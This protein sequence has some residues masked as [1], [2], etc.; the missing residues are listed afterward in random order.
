[1]RLLV[2]GG[3]QF[4]GRLTV[5][6]LLQE[7]HEVVLLNRGRTANPFE[8]RQRLKSIKCDRMGGREHFRDVV[9]DVGNTDAVIDFIGFQEPYVQDTLEALTLD[10]GGKKGFATRH[11]I[12]VSTDS[13]YWAQKIPCGDERLPEDVAEDFSTQEF[14]R[15]LDYC[16][17]TALGEYQL[18]YGG[19]KLG[20]ER[21]LQETWEADGFPYTILRLPDVYGQYDNLGGFWDLVLAIEMRRPIPVQMQPGRIRTR[22]GQDAGDPATRRFS[23]VFAEDVSDAILACLSKG[24]EVHGK[25]MHIAHEEAVNL[26]ET[27]VMIAEAMDVRATALRFDDRR[28]AALP[29]TD[30]GALDVSRALRLLRPWRPTTMRQA[31]QRSVKWFLSSKYN[32]RYHRLVHRELRYYDETTVCPFKTFM[33]ELRSCWVGDPE[34]AA[35]L[36]EGPVVLVD[37]LPNFT[38]QSVL[39]FMQRLMD[40]VGDI[41]IDCEVQRGA[42]VERQSWALRHFAGHLLQQSQHTAAYRL[43]GSRALESTDLLPE[44]ESPLADVRRDEAGSPAPRLLHLGGAGARTALR[45]VPSGNAAGSRGFWDC[46]LLGRRKWRLF[47][48]DTPPTALCVSN[49]SDESPVDV[50]TCGPDMAMVQ[51]EHRAFAPAVCWEYEQT[52]GDA[53]VVPNGW[54]YQTYDD[55]RTL[56]ISA[57]YGAALGSAADSGKPAAGRQV[58][59][60]GPVGSRC[61]AD[62]PEVMEWDVVD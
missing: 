28:P 50:F 8:G 23:W 10:A 49:K 31:V 58:L 17:L 27:A 45:R 1:M 53:V 59:E 26:R 24:K 22:D 51:L 43:L 54:W 38:G 2:I 37:S 46:A 57:T 3:T 14:D 41:Q 44:L 56:S 40:Q 16:K 5:E 30:F 35:H 55:D 12:F 33:C 39:G 61:R 42:E 9:R 34:K 4:M 48:P 18:R 15:H 62:S 20:C 52:M 19:N 11:Y 25:S 32:R 29:S 36:E 6:A 21:L 47:P 60:Q 7:G 13:V